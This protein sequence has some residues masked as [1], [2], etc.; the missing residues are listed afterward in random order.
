[1]SKAVISNSIYLTKPNKEILDK[2]K[3][4]LTYKIPKHTGNKAIERVETIR[5]YKLLKGNILMMPQG[6]IDLIPEDYEIVDKRIT[7]EVEFPDPLIPMRKSQVPVHEQVNDSCIINAKPGWGKSYM[8]LF[9]AHKLKQRTLVVAHTTIIRSGWKAS[10]ENM[11]GIKCGVIGSG[12]VD[13][14]DYPITVSNTQTLVKHADT[15]SKYFGLVIIDECHRT[16][17]TTFTNI[18]SKLHA[19]YRI[20]LSGTI[21]RKDGKHIMLPDF[22]S[23]TIHQPVQSDVLYP[24]VKLIRTGIKLNSD[25]AWTDRVTELT[26][27]VDYQNLVAGI[28]LAYMNK[29][30]S[31]LVIAD[32]VDF[33]AKVSEISKGRLALVA[34]SSCSTEQDRDELKQKMLQREVLGV[35]GSRQIFSEGV[36]IDALSCVVLATPINNDSLLE[37]ICGRVQRPFDDKKPKPVVVDMQFAGYLDKRQNDARLSF[38]M[39]SGW[40]IEE[41]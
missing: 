30:H 41:V 7:S 33:L 34:G 31:V 40:D 27:I 3:D 12:T 29:G 24:S 28:A 35:A 18:L 38:Y 6:R 4:Q 14:E 21:Q 9:I 26:N 10:V 36:S 23:N 19:R 11:F 32:R 37:Q 13:Y 25:K 8:A 15:L 2:I 16:P 22:F 5:N 1:M 20:G 17:S 39:R